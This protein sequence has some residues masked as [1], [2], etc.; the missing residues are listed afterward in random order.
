MLRCDA[1]RGGIFVTPAAEHPINTYRADCTGPRVRSTTWTRCADAINPHSL[2]SHSAGCQRVRIYCS[3]QCFVRGVHVQLWRQLIVSWYVFMKE[4][5][6]RK[7]RH[8]NTRCK[9]SK[10]ID[11]II[12][13]K[14]IIYREL[15]RVIIL[16]GMRFVCRNKIR[17]VSSI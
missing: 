15:W 4:H 13:D 11:C 6:A 7:R 2:L 10:G 17:F 12:S 8:R 9:G 3:E 5:A 16:V 1:M 14:V